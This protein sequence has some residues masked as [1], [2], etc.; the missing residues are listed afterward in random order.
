M[1]LCAFGSRI[2]A[3]SDSWSVE[4]KTRPVRG[5]CDDSQQLAQNPIG[6][7][8]NDT[9][10]LQL[11]HHS[12]AF[13]F[14]FVCSRYLSAVSLSFVYC[15]HVVVVCCFFRILLSSHLMC[16]CRAFIILVIIDNKFFSSVVIR[17]IVYTHIPHDCAICVYGLNNVPMVFV[18]ALSRNAATWLGSATI[19][20][21][22][23]I[24]FAFCLY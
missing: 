14:C 8:T 4:R 22:H 17:H 2:R 10:R 1:N 7:K 24:L 6:N 18:A 20:L 3:N 12:A 21:A 13:T 15:F 23:L 5:E 19:L 9:R 16:G 11:T